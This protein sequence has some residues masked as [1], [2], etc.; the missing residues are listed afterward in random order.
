MIDSL[1]SELDLSEAPTQIGTM[2]DPVFGEKVESGFRRLFE[3]IR[4]EGHAP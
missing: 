4:S 3:A 1:K 2:A